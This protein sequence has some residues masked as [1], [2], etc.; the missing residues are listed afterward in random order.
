M[1]PVS[2]F[3]KYSNGDNAAVRGSDMGGNDTDW[4]DVFEFGVTEERLSFKIKI[5]LVGRMI[6]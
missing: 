6:F 5:L 1:A 2:A 3:A 4:R